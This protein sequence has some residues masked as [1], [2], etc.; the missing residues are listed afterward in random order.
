MIW[1]R[2]LSGATPTWQ[3]IEISADHQAGNTRAAEP[4]DMDGD[5]DL[6]IAVT[7]WISENKHGVF[8]LENDGTPLDE[9]D[10]GWQPHAISGRNP[11]IKYDHSFMRDLDQDGDL[12]LIT[13]EE[14]EADGGL[15]CYLV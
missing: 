10:G 7:T 6:D 2:R 4:G 9:A 14:H 12:D 3:P 11:G 5:G 15:G 1:L 13:C 8:W